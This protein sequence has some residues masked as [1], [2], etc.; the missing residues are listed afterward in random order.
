MDTSN[1]K[2]GDAVQPCTEAPTLRVRQASESAHPD[3]KT[4]EGYTT[5][6][7]IKHFLPDREVNLSKLNQALADVFGEPALRIVNL[8]L[9]IDEDYWK[10]MCG[11][12]WSGNIYR[13]NFRS[14]EIKINELEDIRNA[15]KLIRQEL[16]QVKKG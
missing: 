14:P 1:L 6:G 11:D 7:Y 5:R 16:D 12:P 13:Y 10:Q 8:Q 9:Q 4:A 15:I 2:P 3:F